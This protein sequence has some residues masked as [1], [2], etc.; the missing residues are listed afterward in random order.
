[1]GISPASESISK[2]ISFPDNPKVFPNYTARVTFR[3]LAYQ[4]ETFTPF[5]FDLIVELHFSPD[6]YTITSNG[7]VLASNPYSQPISGKE[8]AQLS[9]AMLAQAFTD[10]KT[11]ATAGN[12]APAAHEK[13]GDSVNPY[14]KKGLEP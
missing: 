13:A 8:S 11:R 14:T 4:G 3:F 2:K 6:H 7:V 9:A 12:A 5:D 1:M 10:I